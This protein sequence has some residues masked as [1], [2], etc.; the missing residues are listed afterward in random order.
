[1]QPPM[2]RVKLDLC[3]DAVKALPEKVRTYYAE[4][5]RRHLRGEFPPSSDDTA[6]EIYRYAFLGE[7]PPRRYR[8]VIRPLLA[9][10][11]LT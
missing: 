7:K 2:D 4:R 1:M 5:F 10:L 8:E 6:L 3:R 11:M 9:A